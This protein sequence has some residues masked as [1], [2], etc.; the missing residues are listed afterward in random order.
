MN[1]QAVEK[2]LRA[3][4]KIVALGEEHVRQQRRILTELER[5]NHPAE[6]ARE[7]LRNY[8]NLQLTQSSI[9]TLSSEN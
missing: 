6:T 1:R 5:D 7:V 3:A 2:H 4:E 9:A 8:E